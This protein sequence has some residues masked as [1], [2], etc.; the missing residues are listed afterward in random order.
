MVPVAD[1]VARYAVQLVQASRPGDTAPDFVT[2][3]VSW[4][5]ARAACRGVAGG[6]GAGIAQGAIPRFFWRCS[7]GCAQCVAPSHFDQF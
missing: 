7:S 3:W 6:E 2:S 5:R 1:P 4:G